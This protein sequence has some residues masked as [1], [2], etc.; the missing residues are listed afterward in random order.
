MNKKATSRHEITVLLSPEVVG[1]GL[2]PA[3]IFDFC[4]DMHEASPY[5]CDF[6]RMYDARRRRPLRARQSVKRPR[7]EL[8]NASE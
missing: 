1:A 5:S 8:P 7:G 2:V 4:A 6:G 3:P